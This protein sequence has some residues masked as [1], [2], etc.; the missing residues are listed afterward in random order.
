LLRHF[1]VTITENFVKAIE[2]HSFVIRPKKVF[3]LLTSWV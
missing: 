1:D 3:Y 2:M